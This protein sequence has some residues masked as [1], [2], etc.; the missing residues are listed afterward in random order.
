MSQL[1]RN[2]FEVIVSTNSVDW[3]VDSCSA[4]IK[5]STPVLVLSDALYRIDANRPWKFD[6]RVEEAL[7]LGKA[8][9]VT[10]KAFGVTGKAFGVTR[11]I[12]EVSRGAKLVENHLKHCRVM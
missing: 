8:F 5:A 11:R 6:C 2:S 10:G 9:G 3:A 1:F 12:T 7:Y 4:F